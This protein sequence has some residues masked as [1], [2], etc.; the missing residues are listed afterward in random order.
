MSA[1]FSIHKLPSCDPYVEQHINHVNE[2]CKAQVCHRP[3][4]NFA[5]PVDLNADY[6][7][8]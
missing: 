2:T 7:I 5:L 6:H 3:S 8:N 4:L 1:M